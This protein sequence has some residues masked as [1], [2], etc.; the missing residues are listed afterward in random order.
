MTTL[1]THPNRLRN[2]TG[3]SCDEFRLRSDRGDFIGRAVVLIRSVNMDMPA[4]GP[5][6]NLCVSET[7]IFL[8]ESFGKEYFVRLGVGLQIHPD[9]DPCPDLAVIHGRRRDFPDADPK[10]TELVVEVSFSSLITDLNIKP[11]LYAEF[12]CPEYWVID[13]R[14]RQLIVHR[15]PIDHDGNF[16]YQT[17]FQL[18][19]KESISPLAKLES[20]I[21][22][23]ELLP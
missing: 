21:I 1:L 19:E 10:S 14:G 5:E 8:R 15:D 3:I 23:R 7:A 4:P 6:H 2:V 17:V 11:A 9:T 13:L 20:S 22:V 16:R 12:G 18:S